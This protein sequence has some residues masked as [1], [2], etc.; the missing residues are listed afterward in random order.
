[1]SHPLAPGSRIGVIAEGLPDLAVVAD[2][3]LRLL[4]TDLRIDKRDRLTLAPKPILLRQ[5]PA[6]A[7]TLLEA[8]C[9]H[10]VVLW[11]SAPYQDQRVTPE[12]EVARFWRE[13][14]LL[15]EERRQK[16]LPPVDRAALCPVPVRKELESWLL[17]DERAL[18][19]YLGTDSHK[20]KVS[21]IKDPEREP[22]PK[23]L[24]SRVF[25]E[26]GKAYGYTDYEDAKV[27]VREIADTARLRRLQ[28][29]RELMSNVDADDAGK[30]RAR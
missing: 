24:L 17:A 3:I 26:H 18:A 29:F 1:M 28:S 16:H 13:C 19:S 20:Q 12:E 23:K 5:A 21:R 2:L 10:V 27:L 7:A 15:D 22:N 4:R 30:R 9:A 8:G 14:D 6:L 11:D 25:K